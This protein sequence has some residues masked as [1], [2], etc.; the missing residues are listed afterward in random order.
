[1]IKHI[2]IDNFLNINGINNV[3]L[4]SISGG[5]I[6]DVYNFIRARKFTQCKYFIL[7]VGSNDCDCANNSSN[8][9]QKIIDEYMVLINY[10]KESYLSSKIFVNQLVP[11]TRTRYSKE[12]FE[13]NRVKLNSYLEECSDENLVFIKHPA[14]E[15]IDKLSTLLY[16]GVHI[17][18]VNGV[19]IYVDEIK[20]VVFFN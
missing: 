15:D 9:T 18:P 19:P 14:F 11:R 4:K 16:D 1:M 3:F 7:T 2:R 17:H 10:L 13:T 8:F 5:K 20:S 6:Q 12:V